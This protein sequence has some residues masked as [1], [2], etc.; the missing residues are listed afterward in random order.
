MRR[1]ARWPISISSTCGSRREGTATW[2]CLA[3]RSAFVTRSRSVNGD[4]SRAARRSWW[5]RRPR[6]PIH[7]VH[8][9]LGLA[10]RERHWQVRHLLDHALFRESA[11]L[12]TLIVGDFNDWL[13]T[14]ARNPFAHHGFTQVTNAA[15]AVSLVPGLLAACLARQG[16]RPRPGRDPPRP[17][18]PLAAGARRLRSSAARHRL[19]SQSGRASLTACRRM[20]L[21]RVVSAAV[22]VRYQKHIYK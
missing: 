16:V 19:S 21:I 9:H 5:S 18:R 15:V 2:C 3:G 8:W 6:G 10:E 13:N 1:W 22:F 11:H 17:D 7:L 4:E 12:P 14:L 20:E